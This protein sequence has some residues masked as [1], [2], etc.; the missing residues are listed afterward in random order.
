M[1]GSSRD[2]VQSLAILN[3][4]MIFCCGTALAMLKQEH[5][6]CRK[7]LLLCAF[8]AFL[9]LVLYLVSLPIELVASS[10]GFA[11]ATDVYAAVNIPAPGQIL[12]LSRDA[13]LGAFYFLFA[14]LSVLLF[15]MQL[16]RD[17]LR[18]ALTLFILIGT[19]SGIVG[20]FQLAGS[21]N[22]LLYFYGI[23]NYGSAVGLFANRNHAAVFLGCLFPMLSVFAAGSRAAAPG[24]KNAIK[25]LAIAAAIILVPLILVTGS[26]TGVLTAIVGLTGGA[27]LYVSHAPRDCESKQVVQRI[28][29][30]AAVVIICLV[31]AT[32]YFSR[33]EA[34]E[35][36]FAQQDGVDDRTVFWASSLK[37]FWHYFPFGFGPGSFVAAFQA[38]EPKAL[39][40]GSYLNRLHNDWLETS[41]AFGVLG[42]LAMLGAVVF[43][44]KR[45]LVL[46]VRLDGARSS[47]ALGRMAS[48]IIAILAIASLSDYPLRTPAMM[49]LFTL[50]CLWFVDTKHQLPDNIKRR[51]SSASNCSVS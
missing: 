40:D 15:A 50:A 22:G 44:I 30:L 46:W 19:I 17:D 1:G 32:I 47:V 21:R 14:P 13:A 29:I 3:P 11:I 48:I 33:A 51:T 36:L 49:G 9:L 38:E 16:D 2:D 42:T 6:E 23:T 12:A 43:Y 45:S 39:L 34:I 35:R 27:L 8:G 41:L 25:L 7:G 24:G 20:V 31:F 26:R 18:L 5:L 28:P 10:K 37:L 4:F